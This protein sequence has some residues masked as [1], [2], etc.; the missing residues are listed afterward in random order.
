M[1]TLISWMNE[2]TVGVLQCTTL[3]GGQAVRKVRERWLA[4]FVLLCWQPS[5]LVWTTLLAAQLSIKQALLHPRLFLSQV[6]CEFFDF[7]FF[8]FFFS[9]D[10]PLCWFILTTHITLVLVY[11]GLKTCGK[12]CHYNPWLSII[13]DNRLET[14]SCNVTIS[15]AMKKLYLVPELKL[16]MLWRAAV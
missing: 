1:L 9:S 2:L 8:F 11:E 12:S 10:L 13:V 15:E 16:M 3:E 6:I 4:C 7:F 5:L 14:L